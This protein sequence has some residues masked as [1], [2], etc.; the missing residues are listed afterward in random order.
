MTKGGE[1]TG[2][3]LIIPEGGQN[4]SEFKIPGH[5][6]DAFSRMCPET[7]NLTRFTK[8][9]LSKGRQST[10][11]IAVLKVV[12]IPI[13]LCNF[14][15]IPLCVLR[16][17]PGSPEFAQAKNMLLND[18]A[19]IWASPPWYR[20]LFFSAPTY[21]FCHRP[22]SAAMRINAITFGYKS[23]HHYQPPCQADAALC[24]PNFPDI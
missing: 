1:S 5:F 18:S 23:F 9:M 24:Q 21:L 6:R 14:Q 11:M 3:N 19:G 13:P 17:M 8:S 2:Q 22:R 16:K 4:T 12:S 20:F 15:A 7:P 10:D